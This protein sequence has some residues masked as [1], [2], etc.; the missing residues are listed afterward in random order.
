MYNV[1]RKHS[2]YLSFENVISIL[3]SLKFR[4]SSSKPIAGYPFGLYC[5]ACAFAVKYMCKISCEALFQSP[6]A[7]ITWLRY[8]R[9][10]RV[11]VRSGLNRVYF[12][13]FRKLQLVV[14]E[15]DVQN[16]IVFTFLKTSIINVYLIA[17]C[18]FQL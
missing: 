5:S 1:Q 18:L 9:Q 10:P 6:P 3:Y 11:Q 8:G 16:V 2:K 7:M 12:T 14:C 15:S 13:E 4:G 17:Q